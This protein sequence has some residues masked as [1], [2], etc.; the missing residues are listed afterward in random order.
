MGK[1]YNTSNKAGPTFPKQPTYRNNVHEEELSKISKK[2]LLK[3]EENRIIS[4]KQNIIKN[5]RRDSDEVRK[6]GS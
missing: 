3:K 6:K 1:S 5:E 2:G 4:N